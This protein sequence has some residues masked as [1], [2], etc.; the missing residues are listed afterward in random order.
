MFL[1]RIGGISYEY[2]DSMTVVE[3]LRALSL[4]EE[5]VREQNQEGNQSSAAFGSVS[6]V[7]K[8]G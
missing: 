5:I 4:C 8:K 2:S 6:G 3:R 1:N 7:A